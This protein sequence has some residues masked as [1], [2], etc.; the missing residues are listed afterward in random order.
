MIRLHEINEEIEILR[1]ELRTPGLHRE[2]ESSLRHELHLLLE[3]KRQITCQGAY[4][5]RYF[6]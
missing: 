1:A 5:I 3:K 4:R 2:D 6:E